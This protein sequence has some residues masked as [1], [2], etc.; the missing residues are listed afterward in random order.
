MSLSKEK[1]QAV[2]ARIKNKSGNLFAPV[3]FSM[4]GVTN[5]ITGATV[6]GA[7]ESVPAYRDDY[8]SAQIDGQIIRSTDFKLLVIASDFTTINPK[9]SGLRV[10][11]NGKNCQVINAELDGADAHYILQVRNG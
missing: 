1:F 9:A 11:V 10:T 4:P 5:P 2:A 3:V 7:T 6:P 8:S